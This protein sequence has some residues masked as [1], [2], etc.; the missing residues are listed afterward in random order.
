MDKTRIVEILNSMKTEDNIE[1]IENAINKV[2]KL[3]DDNIK[4]ICAGKSEEEVKQIIENRLLS[5][6]KKEQR[7]GLNDMFYYG[8]NG[9]TV[10]IH[11]VLPDLHDMKNKLGT[12]DFEKYM[13]YKLEDALSSL[14]NVFKKDETMEEVFAVSPIFYHESSRK[15][16]EDL[17]FEK[18]QECLPNT[19]MERFI[20]M[21]NKDGSKNKKVF[22]TRIKREDFLARTY[23]R[24]SGAR[25]D[26]D[27][28]IP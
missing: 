8:R 10:H 13:K 19:N 4:K 6:K 7:I 24:Y 18:V 5:N 22:Y 16:H 9:N 26:N 20:D 23:N 17:G 3:T 27:E 12:Q 25:E 14:Q 2:N 1:K 15:M 21:F 28:Y 11:L